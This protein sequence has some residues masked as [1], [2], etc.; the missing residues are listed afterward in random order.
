MVEPP[1]YQVAIAA[2]PEPALASAPEPGSAVCGSG[3][4]LDSA[5]RCGVGHPLASQWSGASRPQR[6]RPPGERVPQGADHD[7]DGVWPDSER[8]E[9]LLWRLGERESAADWGAFLE[10]LEAQGIR[11]VQGLRRSSM[12]GAR[13]PFLPCRRSGWGP[14]G[15]A[16]SSTDAATSP[17]PF[18]SATASPPGRA[19]LSRYAT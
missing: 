5:G 1:L 6:P 10:V 2:N 4:T 15:N 18:A 16:A 9:I 17:E 7:G 12:T 14:S 19:D 11:G 3:D 13:G 8:C